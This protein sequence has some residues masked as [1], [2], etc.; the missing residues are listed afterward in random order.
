MCVLYDKFPRIMCCYVD[1]V[2]LHTAT[3]KH[4]K[5]KIVIVGKWIQ[6]SFNLNELASKKKI[7]PGIEHIKAHHSK[8][9]YRKVRKKYPIDF[10][11]K[12]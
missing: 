9:N 10:T 4:Q 8:I 12:R 5:N 11:Q 7:I 1:K 2:S 6:K 3:A